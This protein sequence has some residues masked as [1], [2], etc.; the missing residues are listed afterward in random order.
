MTVLTPPVSEH[1]KKMMEF[2]AK[3]AKAI[4]HGMKLLTFEEIAAQVADL[5]KDGETER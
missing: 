1:Q 2:K 4:E 5:R 3:R